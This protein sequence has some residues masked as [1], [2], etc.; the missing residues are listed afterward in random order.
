MSELLTVDELREHVKTSLGD[1]ALQRYIDAEDAM[2][3]AALGPPGNI[4]DVRFPRGDTVFLLGRKPSSIVSIVERLWETD[5]TLDPEDYVVVGTTLR[6]LDTGPHPTDLR[7]DRM[8]IVYTAADDLAVRTMALIKLVA[9]DVRQVDGV[10]ILART[11]G[12]HSV[13]YASAEAMSQ[14]R[15]DIWAEL[16]GAGAA[17]PFMA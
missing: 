15:D 7:I 12:L 1:D 9:L 4:T 8:T 14:A 11:V 6:R 17:A 16:S 5:T 3:L 10:A 13:Q 2:I